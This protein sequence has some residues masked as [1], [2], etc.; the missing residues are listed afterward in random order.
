MKLQLI[1]RQRLIFRIENE[2]YQFLKPYYLYQDFGIFKKAKIK[3]S[4]MGWNIKG[5]F[6]SQNQLREIINNN[7]LLR[8]PFR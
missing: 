7:E 5:G 3:G 1:D 2:E 4:T 8:P 6:V